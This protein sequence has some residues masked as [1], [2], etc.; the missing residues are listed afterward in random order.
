MS[1]KIIPWKLIISGL[2]QDISPDDKIL[3]EQW[4][5][6]SENQSL[7]EELGNIWESIKKNATEYHPDTDY[8]WKELQSRIKKS[9]KSTFFHVGI[10]SVVAVAAAVVLVV[11]S[12]SVIIVTSDIK[13]SSTM[14]T[15]T[16]F[17]GKS[18]VILPD[19]STVWLNKG[20]TIRY[21]SLFSKDRN[22]ELDGEGLFDV[23][24]N[25][26]SPFI[27]HTAGI[28]VKV[29]GTLFNVDSYNRDADVRVALIEGSVSIITKNKEMHL[30]PGEIAIFHKT[31]QV[32]S[33]KRLPYDPSDLSNSMANNNTLSAQ[34]K[35]ISKLLNEELAYESFWASESLSFDHKDL[36]YICKY[37]EKWYK[38]EINIDSSLVKSQYYTFT[39][40][41]E[42]LEQ[43]LRN[44]NKINPISY[45]FVEENVINITSV[46]LKK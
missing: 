14:Q 33:S 18:K 29:Y 38:V 32:L 19:G 35:I 28:Q 5:A 16:S 2:K 41:D 13:E 23:T 30:V 46:N 9:K 25:P 17:S 36:G 4:L 7:Y 40:K 37:L 15:Y 34:N 43:I 6:S 3:L 44:M 1:K 26:E 20:S 31:D 22:L 45:S 24:K 12:A 11:I 8:Y 39:L 10:K 27:V 21:S 42:P